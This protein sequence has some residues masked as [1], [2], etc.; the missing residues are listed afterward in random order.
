MHELIM[1]N[2]SQHVIQ[3]NFKG[4]I[5]FAHRHNA[6]NTGNPHAEAT[7]NM[8][9]TST[10]NGR[11]EQFAPSPTPAVYYDHGLSDNDL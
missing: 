4:C 9:A 6:N 5:L 3:I 2:I 7:P 11:V 10:D 8:Y 1:A